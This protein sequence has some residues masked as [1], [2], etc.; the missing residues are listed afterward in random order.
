MLSVVCDDGSRPDLTEV[1]PI[2]E[3][4]GARG[5][6]AIC[7]S[8]LIRPNYLDE[9]GVAELAARGHELASHLSSHTR[10]SQLTSANLQAEIADNVA[11]LTRLGGQVT[12]LAYPY[13]E[14]DRRTRAL[15]AQQFRQ[16]LSTWPG[17]VS[18]RINRYAL[19]RVGFGSYEHPAW[20]V[21]NEPE[22]WLDQL[23]ADRSWLILMLHPGAANRA[24]SHSAGLERLLSAAADRRLPVHTVEQASRIG[25]HPVN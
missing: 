12:T 24:A 9:A 17:L 8:Y 13:G 1:A 11:L 2:L 15:A 10:A 3:S 23:M 20:P 14:S 18:G 7:S 25:L 5:T 6:F 16:A 4:H 19:R 22:R 21:F